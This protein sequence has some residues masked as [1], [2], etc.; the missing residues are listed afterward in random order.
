MFWDYRWKCTFADRDQL[1]W[2]RATQGKNG[3]M[4]CMIIKPHHG[5]LISQDTFSPQGD[6]AALWAESF[7]LGSSFPKHKNWGPFLDRDLATG[8]VL[9][10]CEERDN[11]ALAGAMSGL[12]QLNDR[13]FDNRDATARSCILC[14]L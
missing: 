13:R 9:S 8:W 10:D 3:T 6:F 4:S 5:Q 7:E 1:H 14:R 12:A 2:R 11:S